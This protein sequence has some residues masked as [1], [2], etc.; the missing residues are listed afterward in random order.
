MTSSARPQSVRGLYTPP[1][2]EWVFLPPSVSPPS[3]SSPSASAPPTHLPSPF[4]P[5]VEDEENLALPM[6]GRPFNL[7]L[8][9]YLTTA[10]GMPFEVGKTLLQVEYRPRRRF[11]QEDELDMSRIEE[12]EEFELQ[13]DQISNPEEADMYFSDRLAQPAAPLV[14]PPELIA[15][16]DASGYLP[17]LHPSYLLMDD[18]EVSRGNGVWGMI[19]RIRHTPSEGLPGLWKSQVV[20]TIH[21]FLS[22]TL[23]P[24]VHSFLLI[25]IPTVEPGVGLDISLSALPNPGIPLALQVGSH[26]LTHILLSPLEIIKT[27]LIVSP[28]NHPSSQ[29]SIGIFR[30][31]IEKEGGFANLYFHSNLL[32]PSVLEHTLRPLL[33]LSI[34]L[35]IER[36]FN[37]SPDLSPITYSLMD[38]SLGLSILL[39]LLPIETVRKRLQL[40]NRGRA[41]LENA[42]DNKLATQSKSIVKLREKGYIGVVE[43]IWRILNE[44]TG[45]RRKRK[46]TERDE[47]G[48]FSGVRQLYRGFGMAATAHMTVFGLG[49]V[50]QV[51]SGNDGGGWKEI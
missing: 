19:R 28:S 42:G 6:M 30:Q 37:I 36:Q 1:A 8:S 16:T 40:Q 22:S 2:E 33:T 17:D 25:L 38:L 34:P 44:E 32:I 49:L 4:T 3:S 41:A 26:L 46:M 48:W 10:M 29:S 13:D 50:S 45:V 20:S 51:L 23:Q 31:L 15:E 14:P 9:E 24:T 39:I 35:L 5:N 18:P 7:F 47:G 27:R 21:S 43:A 11:V 12:K